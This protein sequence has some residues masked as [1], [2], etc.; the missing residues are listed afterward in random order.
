MKERV[1]KLLNRQLVLQ[2]RAD[3]GHRA[4][5][6]FDRIRSSFWLL[7]LVQF[8]TLQGGCKAVQIGGEEERGM[9][10]DPFFVYGLGASRYF[11][12]VY[13]ESLPVV[14]K[15]MDAVCSKECD[16]L[17]RE[18]TGVEAVAVLYTGYINIPLVVVDGATTGITAHYLYLFFLYEML[19]DLIPYMLMLAYDDGR[20]ILPY[21][22]NLVR[23]VLEQ[24]L[25]GR[26]VEPGIGTGIV[27]AEHD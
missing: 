7:L 24:I 15:G 25:F 23:N 6:G 21:H 1:L 18:F 19:V 5:D 3:I 11:Q 14:G 27:D 8:L 17:L 9:M 12:A 16:Q 26:Q 13:G 2:I 4:T 20:F 22:E 10:Q